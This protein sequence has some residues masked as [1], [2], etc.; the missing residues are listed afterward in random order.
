MEKRLGNWSGCSVSHAGR[1]VHIN[2]CLSSIPSYA[3]GFYQ[4][5]EGIHQKFN[6]IRGRYYWAGNKQGRKYHTM[7]WADLIFPK[8]FVGLGLTETRMF[9]IA[10]L[11]KWLV[12]VES[13]DGSLCF[14][15]LRKK[16]LCSGGVFQC[17]TEG[18]SQF[19]SRILNTRKW[20]M[21]GSELNRRLVMV[22]IFGS[23]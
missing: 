15:L 3:M 7:N 14:E 8:E 18:A 9:N 16:Y 19:W 17:S 20:M 10:L 4:L 23:G 5:Y 6:S 22:P 1:A 2:A 13:P 21:L 11:A 12:K